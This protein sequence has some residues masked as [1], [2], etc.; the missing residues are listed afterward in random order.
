MR[1]WLAALD[2]LFCGRQ[3]RCTHCGQAAAVL[4][5]GVFELPARAIAYSLCPK[6]KGTGTDGDDAVVQQIMERR[7]PNDGG[8]GACP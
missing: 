1:D 7:Y 4:T 6:C 5:V 8:G 3:H 2:T